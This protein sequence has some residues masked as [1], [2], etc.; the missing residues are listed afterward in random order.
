MKTVM[1]KMIDRCRIAFQAKQPLIFIDTE[2]QELVRELALQCD[3]VDLVRK[4]SPHGRK[5][6][7]YYEFIDAITEDENGGKIDVRVQS[8]IRSQK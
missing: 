2:E 6:G 7:L 8:Y 5:H 1:K 3:L 4:P